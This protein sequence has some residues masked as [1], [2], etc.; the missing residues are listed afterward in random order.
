MSERPSEGVSG[1]VCVCDRSIVTRVPLC[2]DY[3]FITF[4]VMLCGLV[5]WH[6]DVFVWLCV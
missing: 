2:L 4:P 3:V 5:S 1:C 6:S